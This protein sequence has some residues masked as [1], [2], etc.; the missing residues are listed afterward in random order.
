MSPGFQAEKFVDALRSVLPQ[1]GRTIGLHEPEFGGNELKYVTQCIEEGWVSSVGKFVDRFETELAEYVGVKRAVAVVNGTAALHVCLL[2]A[3]VT[4]DDE[5][6][7]PAMTFVA[8]AN[9]VSYC[10]AVPHFVDSEERTLGIDA[11]KLDSYLA[12]IADMSRGECINTQTGRRIRAVVPMHTFGHAVD[13]DALLDVCARYKL[14]LVEDA[15][16]SLGTFYKNKHTGSYGSLSALSFNGN[17][18][19][20]TGGGGAILTNDEK[21]GRLAKHITT[22]AKINDR[23]NFVHDMIGYNYRMPNINA[24]LGCGQLEQLSEFLAQKKALADSYAKAFRELQGGK[25]FVA[26]EFSQSNYWL[27]TYLLDPQYEDMRDSV[28]ELTNKQGFMTR[29]VWRLMYKLPMYN[30]CPRMDS[31]VAE[32]LE[33]RL[34][35]LPSSACL[36]KEYAIT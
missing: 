13:I 29:P 27:N 21:L 28:L 18:I 8:T 26:P 1:D 30:Q 7:I 33:R 14:Q 35:N 15:A 5:V 32:S 17:K 36:G 4:A 11:A 23:W 25:F 12:D 20:T 16:E 9:A 10:N 3:G 19:L 22:T 6:I 34:I 24:A 31:P 2:L